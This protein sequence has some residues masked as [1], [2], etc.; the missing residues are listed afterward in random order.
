M[1]VFEA[2]FVVWQADKPERSAI[3]NIGSKVHC[4]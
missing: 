1:A 2:G 4:L 3:D